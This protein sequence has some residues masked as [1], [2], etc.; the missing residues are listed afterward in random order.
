MLCGSINRQLRARR[1][2]SLFKVVSLR[3]RRALSRLTLYSDTTLLVLNGTSLN[4]DYALLALM[5]LSC[6]HGLQTAGAYL[7]GVGGGGGDMGLSPRPNV[8]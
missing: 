7:P 3:T 1:A 8:L 5:V 2:L 6:H 4:F